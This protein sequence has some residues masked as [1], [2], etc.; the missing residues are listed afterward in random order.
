MTEILNAALLCFTQ[1]M[2]CREIIKDGQVYLRRY[3]VQMN[4]DGSQKWLHQILLADSDPRLHSHSWRAEV[5]V[6]SG[7]YM[8]RFIDDYERE[9]IQWRGSNSGKFTIGFNHRHRIFKVRDFTWTELNVF[10]QRLEGFNFFNTDGSMELVPTAGED[11]YMNAKTR[12][13]IE[14]DYVLKIIQENN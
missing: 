5:V 14:S 10:P 8:E 6:L 12:D 2:P 13:G 7:G 3:F 11:W 4:S 1:D 9:E